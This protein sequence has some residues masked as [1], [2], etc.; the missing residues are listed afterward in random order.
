MLKCSNLKGD[1]TMNNKSEKNISVWTMLV[2]LLPQVA[3]VSPG[4]FIL[5][6]LFFALNG[7]SFAAATLCMQKLF[8]KVTDLA[9]N[10]GTLKGVIF[11]L[12]LLFIVKILEEVF[13][14]IANFIGETYDPRAVGKLSRSVNLKMDRLD[15]ISFENTEVLD[16]I[17]KSYTGIRLAINFMNTIM[18]VM[19]FYLPYF[20]FMG[21]YLFK[22]KPI[23]ALSLP[24]VFFPVVFSQLIRVRVFANLEDNSAPL[25]RKAKYYENCLAGREYLKETRILGA[26]P[27]F[28]RLFKEALSEMN[29]LKWKADVKTNLIELSMK[30][31]SLMGYVVILWMLFHALMKR[32]ITIGAFAAVFASVDSMFSMMEGVVCGRLGYYAK[33]FGKIQNYL[34]FLDLPERGGDE[35]IEDSTLHGDIVLEEVSFSYPLSENNAVEKVNLRIHKGETIAVV[36]E[37][38][39]GK[40]TLMRL[41]TGIYLPSSGRV[42]HNDKATRDL[43]P[44]ALFNGIS[45]VFQKF[46]RYQ[47]TLSNNITISEMYNKLKSEEHMKTATNQA[48]IQVDSKDFPKGY[49]TMLSR[50]FEGVDLSGGQWQKVAIARGF[51]RKHELIILDEPTS[52]IDPIEETK[53]YERFAEI[54]KDKTAVIVTHRLGSV[55]FADRIVV[56][57]KGKIVGIGNHEY[58]LATCSIYRDMWHS[59]A[60]HYR[61]DNMVGV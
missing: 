24:L 48:G 20:L 58:L 4:L 17:N 60:Q 15:P 21:I 53:I 9:V 16:H 10:R 50:E 19:L 27:Y 51:Y 11:A 57:K 14:G 46:Q 34:R 36:G 37:N 33:N 42:L 1:G 25:R 6:Y 55:K 3:C 54:A 23:L 38:G 39:S 44:K 30:L 35:K 40:S 12:I 56:M 31:I 18:D 5:T 8:D 29:K 2:K 7:I 13:S 41:I 45:G 43:P 59:Q 26:S 32:E 28:M 52:A 47:L 61:T 49:D 22:L